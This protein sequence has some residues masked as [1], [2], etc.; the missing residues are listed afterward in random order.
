MARCLVCIEDDPEVIELLRLIVARH[1]FEFIEA[2]G[3]AK[4]IE[5]VKQHLPD[6]VLLDLMMPGLDGWEVFDLLRGDPETKDIPIIV[7]TAR[8]HFDERVAEM[9][10]AN[11]GNLLTK[12]FI[13]QQLIDAIYR[14]LN[15]T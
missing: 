5:L 4:G 12:P 3:G 10:A 1:G 8:A 2:R 15:I 11:D 9:R 7:V 6:L 14:V 13:P